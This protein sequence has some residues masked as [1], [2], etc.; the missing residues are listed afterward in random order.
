MLS[1]TVCSLC[2]VTA[3]FWAL[4]LSTPM[5]PALPVLEPSS[6]DGR[7]YGGLDNRWCEGDLGGTLADLHNSVGC[8]A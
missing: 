3:V 5:E 1:Y 8:D 7:E 2:W 4:L 6:K